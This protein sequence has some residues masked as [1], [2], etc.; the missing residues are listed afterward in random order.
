[1][2]AVEP[3]PPLRLSRSNPSE[4]ADLTLAHP[5]RQRQIHTNLPKGRHEPKSP[6]THTDIHRYPLFLKIPLDSVSHKLYYVNYK[7]RLDLPL[8]EALWNKPLRPFFPLYLL[9]SAYGLAAVAAAA[10]WFASSY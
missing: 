2:S 3:Q 7:M 10:F 5:P 4:P 6:A 1:M 9:D 8:V